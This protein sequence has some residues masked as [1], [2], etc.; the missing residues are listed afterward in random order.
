MGASPMASPLSEA[1][2]RIKAMRLR[3]AK[4]VSDCPP[5]R[6]G[7]GFLKAAAA[8]A[9]VVLMGATAL[10]QGPTY[11]LGRSPSA[12]QLRAWDISISPSGDELPVGRGTSKE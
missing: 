7:V 8:L 11:G 9:L 2:P 5:L 10:A 4:A 1:S 3:L 12:E 6:A